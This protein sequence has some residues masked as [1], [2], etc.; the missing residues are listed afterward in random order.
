MQDKSTFSK[1]K[2][3]EREVRRNLILDTAVK[4][5]AERPFEKV[6]LREIA[7]AAGISPASI[8]RYFA[9]R[10]DLF[11]EAFIREGKVL[12]SYLEELF[13]GTGMVSLEKMAVAYIDFLFD[14]DTFFKMMTYFMMSGKISKESLVKL[15]EMARQI[16]NIFDRA[17][18]GHGIKEN[19]R[20]YS[21]VFFASLNGIMITFR[22]YPGRKPKEVR[23][24]MHRLASFLAGHFISQ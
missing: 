21:H 9:D 5:F 8:Y 17:F 18:L 13:T 7:A 2:E 19:V 11:V 3:A 24:H 12:L 14:H 4:I 22:N 16:L 23:H 15:N 1:L 6:S 20:L 10:D